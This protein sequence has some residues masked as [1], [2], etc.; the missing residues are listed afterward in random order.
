MHVL[1]QGTGKC[2]HLD[3]TPGICTVENK[4]EKC[5][6][7]SG[8][9]VRDDNCIGNYFSMTF[10]NDPKVIAFK[11]ELQAA[12]NSVTQVIFYIYIM[13]YRNILGKSQENFWMFFWIAIVF[14]MHWIK[15]YKETIFIFNLI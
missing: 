10:H 13:W 4:T 7:P 8:F 2:Y 5:L 11:S 15:N 1:F 6:C 14:L 9:T 12:G 3:C